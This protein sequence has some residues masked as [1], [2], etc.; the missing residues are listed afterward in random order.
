MS[1]TYGKW[2]V[3]TVLNFSGAA[4]KL[5]A[6]RT[7]TTDTYPFG[8]HRQRV[9]K[10]RFEVG[11]GVNPYRLGLVLNGEPEPAP[12]AITLQDYSTAELKAEVKRRGGK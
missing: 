5:I 1:V 3:S 2:T 11:G 10:E 6:E 4:I 12:P 9:T 7:V 8:F